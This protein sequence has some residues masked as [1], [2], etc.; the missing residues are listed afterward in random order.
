M[1]VPG[2]ILTIIAGAASR[3]REPSPQNGISSFDNLA[4]RSRLVTQPDT[5]IL[6][7]IK[8]LIVVLTGTAIPGNRFIN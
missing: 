7:V 6:T 5:A 2:P 4:N 3:P 1:T 8:I